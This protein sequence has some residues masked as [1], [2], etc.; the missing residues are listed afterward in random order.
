MSIE[1]RRSVSSFFKLRN[2]HVTE[3]SFLF[4]G[5]AVEATKKDSH[6]LK[7]RHNFHLTGLVGVGESR[8]KKS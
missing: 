7:Y 3:I 5:S 2:Y 6:V 8:T 1:S 4:R